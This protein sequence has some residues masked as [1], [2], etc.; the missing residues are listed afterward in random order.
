MVADWLQEHVGVELS[1]EKTRI[2]HIDKGFDFLG[3]NIR[4]YSGKLL[5]KPSRDSR[6][7]ILRKIKAT[8]DTNK[9]VKAETIIRTLNPLVRGWANYYSTVVSKREFSYCDHRIYQMLWR[10]AKRR[11]PNKRAKWVKVKYFAR[12]GTRNWMF[13]DGKRDLLHMSDFPITRH[14]KVQGNRSPYRAQDEAYFERRR[15][16]LLLKRLDGFQKRVVEK[17]DGKCGLCGR[18]ISEEHFR[19]WK[20]HGKGSI[21]FHLMIPESLGGNH[22]TANVFVTHRS[23]QQQYHKN[24]GHDTMPDSP[25]RFLTFG[26]SIV[27]GRVVR[28]SESRAANN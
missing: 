8:L 26:E 14:T 7:S 16:Q 13:T 19:K 24:Y 3:F 6:Q 22:T 4:K 17:T 9:T 21:R 11:H 10:W 12:R 18:P 23:C 15:Q 20:L 1:L 27:Q 28:T 5:I 25:W 2:T